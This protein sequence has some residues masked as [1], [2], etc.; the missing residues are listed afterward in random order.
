[1]A[2]TVRTTRDFYHVTVTDREI[3]VPK[4]IGKDRIDEAEAVRRATRI[5]RVRDQARADAAALAHSAAKTPEQ[6]AEIER[7]RH[8]PRLPNGA[9]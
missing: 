6:I 8:D 5:Q 1:M 9:S 7:L 3:P 4:G 2:A